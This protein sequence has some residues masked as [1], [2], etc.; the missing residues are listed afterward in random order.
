MTDNV[1]VELDIYS[2]VPNPAWTLQAAEAAEFQRKLKSLPQTSGG[3]IDNNLG[4][5]GFVVRTGPTTAQVQRGTVKVV[6]DGE[7]VFR[8]DPGRQLE[9]WLLQSGK[10]FLETATFTLAE[11]EFEK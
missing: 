8:T 5:R 6:K 2:G 7:T 11:R 4:Y 1:A 3:R 10:P 9:R